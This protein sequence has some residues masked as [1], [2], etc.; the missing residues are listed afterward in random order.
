M[1]RA[2]ETLQSAQARALAGRP[3]IGGFPFLA[4]TLRQ[5]GAIRNE[6]QL[7]ACQS[8]YL[9]QD[10]PVIV[11]GQPLIAGAV[12]VP[13]FD[14]A[15]LVRALRTDQAGEGTF[16]EFLMAAWRAGVVR[17]EVDFTARTVAYFG[18]HGETYLEEYP[19]VAT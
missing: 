11:Q 8:L 12:D 4:E 15:A 1:S 9:M 10:G 17:Y 19:A 7:P 18:C 13:A 6:W 14:Q 2:V 16:A 3:A 5:A